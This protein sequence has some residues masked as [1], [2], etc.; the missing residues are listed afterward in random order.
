MPRP[1][2]IIC[3]ESGAVDSQTGLVSLF[4][5][6]ER[7]HTAPLRAD[8]TQRPQ[9][10]SGGGQ[11]SSMRCVAMW[12]KLPEDPA[13]AGYQHQMLLIHPDGETRLIVEDDDVVFE[14]DQMPF[15]RFMLLLGGNPFMKTGLARIQSRIRRV[16]SEDWIAQDYPMLVS[17]I[18]GG[19]APPD[20]G[21]HNESVNGR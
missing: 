14:S 5:I 12:M 1:V 3:C 2:Y 10:L 4:N 20:A 21:G 11:L 19:G 18:E 15:A 8:A 16:E 7:F 13:G 9:T 6:C 17:V